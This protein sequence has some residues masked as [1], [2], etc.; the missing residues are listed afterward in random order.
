VNDFEKT[1]RQVLDKKNT[2]NFSKSTDSMYY[3]C[4]IKTKNNVGVTGIG[5]S[6]GRSLENA[7][8]EGLKEIMVLGDIPNAKE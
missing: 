2:V 1:L 4:V 8:G 5:N 3:L 6:V 7:I